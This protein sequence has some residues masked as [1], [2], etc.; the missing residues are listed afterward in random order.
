MHFLQFLQVPINKV[1]A[2][3]TIMFENLMYLWKSLHGAHDHIIAS[4]MFGF[5]N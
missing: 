1:N 4:I 5:P 2:I 3:I